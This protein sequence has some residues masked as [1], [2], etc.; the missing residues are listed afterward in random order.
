MRYF[1]SAV[2]FLTVIPATSSIPPARAAF[3]FPLVG[4]MIGAIAGEIGWIG[5]LP[6]PIV[7]LLQLLFMVVIT[8]GLHEDGLA[9][10]FD[11]FRA[12]RA[13]E[14]I[15]AILK[16]SRVGVYGALALGLS[17]LFRWQA[18]EGLGERM[19]AIAASAGA[20]RGV[21]VVLAYISKPAGE[22]IGKVFLS[23]LTLGSTVSAGLQSAA[24]P[25]LVSP[26][27]GATALAGNALLLAVGRT[28]FHRRI[29]GVTGDCL[30]AIC[31]LSEILTLLIFLCFI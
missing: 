29:G 24:L 11:A 10:V 14:R 8:G 4:A 17:L 18:L 3:F 5:A 31:Q 20:S 7:A 30:G 27:A 1:R 21:M 22:G 19:P 6:R 16:D 9:D 2:Q 12:G 13:P 15:H 28:Y 26:V 25:F 23:D